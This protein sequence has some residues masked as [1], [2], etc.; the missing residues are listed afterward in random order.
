MRFK[1]T[2]GLASLGL[3]ST[4]LASLGL[5]SL[6]VLVV[7]G[8][9]HRDSAARPAKKSVPLG[10]ATA[11][12][13][14][15]CFWCM[16]PAFDAIKGVYATT[17]GYTGGEEVK[18]TYEQVSSGRTGHCEAMQVR[19]DPKQVSFEKLLNVFWRNIDPLVQDRQFCDRGKQYRSAVFYGNAEEKRQIEASVVWVKKHLSKGVL[20]TQ[21]RPTGPFYPAEEYHQD[22]YK[23]KPGHYKAYRRGCRRDQRLKVLW[24]AKG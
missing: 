4:G 1:T 19:Y 13:C 21:V 23:K 11:T 6:L 9:C 3:A 12:F 10:S 18:P 16:E 24:G 2:L 20:H 14:G 22:F 5:A 17:S 7:P 8:G 15:G